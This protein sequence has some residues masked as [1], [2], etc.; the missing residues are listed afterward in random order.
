MAK[1]KKQT[2]KEEEKEEKEPEI[3]EANEKEES[4]LEEQTEQ[5]LEELQEHFEGFTPIQGRFSSPVLEQAAEAPATPDIEWNLSPK[6]DEEKKEEQK[7]NYQLEEQ[8]SDYEAP[9]QQDTGF[10]APVLR[11]ERIDM[12]SIGRSPQRLGR[13]AHMMEWDELRGKGDEYNVMETEKI[14]KTKLGRDTPKV[15]REYKPKH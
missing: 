6:R 8:V 7:L 2:N 5:G 14:D 13:E 12:Q 11:A 4:E 1:K 9:Q 3:E 10:S 15:G